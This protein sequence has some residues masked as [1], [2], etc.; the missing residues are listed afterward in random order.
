MSGTAYFSDWR[1][2]FWHRWRWDVR[3]TS[4]DLCVRAGSGVIRPHKSGTRTEV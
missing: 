1:C 2:F 3:D 4:R